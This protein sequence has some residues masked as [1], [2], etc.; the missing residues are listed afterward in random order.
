L[1]APK[2]PCLNMEW[3]KDHVFIAAW[4]SPI[5]ALIG[6]IVKKT[7]EGSP[8]NWSRVMIYVAFLTCLAETVTPGVDP[9]VWRGASSIVGVGFGFLIYDSFRQH[10]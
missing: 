5:I 7:P 9:L 3:F 6:M 4:A 10:H 1:V 2:V 8:L